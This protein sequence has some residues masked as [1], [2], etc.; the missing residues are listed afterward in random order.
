MTQVR[1]FNQNRFGHLPAYHRQGIGA[2]N[3]FGICNLEIGI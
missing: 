3:L 1:N 2:W